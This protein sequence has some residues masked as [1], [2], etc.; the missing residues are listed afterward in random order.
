VQNCL[1]LLK[2]LPIFGIWAVLLKTGKFG[3]YVE[4]LAVAI[5]LYQKYALKTIVIVIG[6]G[7]ASKRTA[8][9][10]AEK[11]ART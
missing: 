2:L 6:L 9:V 7:S 8:I 5:A 11:R 4:F 1:I 10:H 3:I